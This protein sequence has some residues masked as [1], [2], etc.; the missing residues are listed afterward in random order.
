MT[1]CKLVFHCGKVWLILSRGP[2]QKG[3]GVCMQARSEGGNDQ[4]ILSHWQL[5]WHFGIYLLQHISTGLRQAPWLP[6]GYIS[7]TVWAETAVNRDPSGRR[8]G[9][10]FMLWH[11]TTKKNM[12]HLPEVVCKCHHFFFT[13]KLI[14]LCRATL[15]VNSWSLL[16][17]SLTVWHL[18]GKGER[19]VRGYQQP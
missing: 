17:F 5:L 9:N 10:L 16:G 19:Q 7:L 1:A 14:C 13:G 6:H 18:R 8:T 2:A 4:C 3:G 11:I 12:H 15:V